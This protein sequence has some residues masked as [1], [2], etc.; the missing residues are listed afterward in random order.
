MAT[1]HVSG[2]AALIWSYDESK[3]AAEVREALTQ[4]AKDLGPEGRDDSYGFGLVQADKALEY[5]TGVTP[6]P[7]PPTP[8]P[9]YEGGCGDSPSGWYD[10]DGSEYDCNWYAQLN[11]CEEYGDG[12]ANDGVT[13]NMACC[14]CGGGSTAA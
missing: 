13:A 10:S 11:R 4:S 1:P 8:S 6:A 12:Y 2:V 3:S 5:L 7:V 14:A 9:T